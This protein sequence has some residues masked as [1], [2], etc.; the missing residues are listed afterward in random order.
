MKNKDK[1]RQGEEI[2]D[3]DEEMK[4]VRPVAREDEDGG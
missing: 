4:S 1:T 3:E 2:E